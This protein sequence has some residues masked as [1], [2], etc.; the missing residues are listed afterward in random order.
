MIADR[1]VDGIPEH[2]A[3]YEAD[4]IARTPPTVVRVVE[5]LA[6][7]VT[8]RPG[9]PALTVGRVPALLDQGDEDLVGIEM[10]AEP[11]SEPNCGLG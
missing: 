7:C 10:R 5:R 6:D 8:G 4:D 9:V 11:G 3:V 2:D 1:T